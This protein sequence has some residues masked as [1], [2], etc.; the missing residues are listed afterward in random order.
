MGLVLMKR[1]SQDL[2]YLLSFVQISAT[3]QINDNVVGTQDCL[4][5]GLWLAVALNDLDLFVW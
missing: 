3:D 4:T 5:K 2:N 1:L